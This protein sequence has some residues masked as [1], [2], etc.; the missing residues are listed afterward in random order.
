MIGIV[1]AT[2]GRITG[3]DPPVEGGATTPRSGTGR[4]PSNG[5]AGI[6]LFGLESP[7]S[8]PAPGG[9]VGASFSGTTVV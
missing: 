3:V 5:V 1:P 8:P 9:N 6:S 2:G 7:R 4:E